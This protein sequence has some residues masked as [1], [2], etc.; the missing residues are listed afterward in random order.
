MMIAAK[1]ISCLSQ[2]TRDYSRKE[3]MK[4]AGLIM[5]RNLNDFLFQHRYR[6][7]DDIN[8]T[9]FG[10]TSWRPDRAAKLTSSVKKRIDK[11]AG[12]IVASKPAP[13]KDDQKVS[14]A[15][16]PLVA[17]TREFLCACRAEQKAEY[18]GH[19]SKYRS[20]LDGILPKIGLPKL[21]KM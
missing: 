7:D 17:Q 1:A 13:F 4:I 3:S 21:P 19:A 10:L 16:L 6:H 9:D 5:A 11:I 15:V 14:D 20:R 12:H 2:V 8:V 18:T